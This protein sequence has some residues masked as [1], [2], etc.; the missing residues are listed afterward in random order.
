VGE[1]VRESLWAKGDD[2]I[3]AG[4]VAGNGAFSGFPGVCGPSGDVRLGLIS[5]WC[6]SSGRK[7]SAGSCDDG[8]AYVCSIGLDR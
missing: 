8:F 2:G 3:G 4:V 7:S 5:G 1:E 6:F